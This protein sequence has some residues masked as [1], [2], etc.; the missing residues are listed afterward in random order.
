MKVTGAHAAWQNALAERRGGILG[1][2]WEA[3]TYEHQSTGYDDCRMVLVAAVTAKNSILT[4]NGRTPE[5]AV[6]GRSLDWPSVT[7]DDDEVHLAIV[8]FLGNAQYLPALLT[9]PQPTAPFPSSTLVNLFDA[10]LQPT[11]L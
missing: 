10:K 2:V 4:R 5:Q 7:K 8:L 9:P 1:E 3:I 6:F 11:P